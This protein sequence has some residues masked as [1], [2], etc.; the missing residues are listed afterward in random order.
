V[1]HSSQE[2]VGFGGKPGGSFEAM[3]MDTPSFARGIDKID[4]PFG[5]ILES[6]R[7]TSKVHVFQT[8]CVYFEKTCPP[9]SSII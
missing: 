9:K 5:P 4:S 7:D 8:A 1:T 2:A 3:G 6:F